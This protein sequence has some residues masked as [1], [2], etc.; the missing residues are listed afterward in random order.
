MSTTLS[1]V[2]QRLGHL[3]EPERAVDVNLNVT[4]NALLGEWLEMRRALF[5]EEQSQPATR[6]PTDCGPDSH[7]PQQRPHGPANA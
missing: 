2:C 5:H 6:E 4:F 7:D 1:Y 3:F